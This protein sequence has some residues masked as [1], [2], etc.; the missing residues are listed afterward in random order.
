MKFHYKYIKTKYYNG[1]K[2]LFTYTDSLVYEIETDD[3]YEDIYENKNLFDY[4]DHPE[5][6][7][8]LS[9]KK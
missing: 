5:D 3:T 7:K 1:S 9:I 6:S 2:L 8:V 4:S